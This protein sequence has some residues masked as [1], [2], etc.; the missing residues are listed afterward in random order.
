MHNEKHC[1]THLEKYIPFFVR[2]EYQT[3]AREKL[4]FLVAQHSA[5]ASHTI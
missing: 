4:Q 1:K 5:F 3:E 2:Y